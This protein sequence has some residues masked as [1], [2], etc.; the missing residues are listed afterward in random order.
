MQGVPG[1][2]RLFPRYF[3]GE[4]RAA[5]F[6]GVRG[7]PQYGSN[8]TNQVTRAMIW[9]KSRSSSKGGASQCSGF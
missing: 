8:K 6:A 4:Q 5:P 1:A 2:A 9:W 3:M 7:V